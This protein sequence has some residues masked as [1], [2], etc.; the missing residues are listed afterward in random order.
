MLNFV[1]YETCEVLIFHSIFNPGA[2]LMLLMAKLISNQVI[3]IM[4]VMSLNV[5]YIVYFWSINGSCVS[6]IDN[7]TVIYIYS[8]YYFI[9]FI[10]LF[11]YF[12]IYFL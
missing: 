4:A 3:F 7:I 1:V 9:L 5:M 6:K 12:I 11:I 10:L 2:Y 8:I